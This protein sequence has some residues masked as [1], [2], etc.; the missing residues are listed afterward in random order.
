[1]TEL[2]CGLCKKKVESWREHV[3]SDEHQRNLSNQSLVD[4]LY[5]QTMT[6]PFKTLIE[7]QKQQMKEMEKKLKEF[8]KG[9]EER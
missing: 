4:E 1:M 2:F 6:A 5:A 8:K 3:V 9:E 7:A